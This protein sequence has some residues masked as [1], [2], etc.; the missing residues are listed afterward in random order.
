MHRIPTATRNW[1]ERKCHLRIIRNI[2]GSIVSGLVRKRRARE[3]S[4]PKCWF[5]M[6]ITPIAICNWPENRCHL[7]IIRNIRGSS[8]SGLIRE[9]RVQECPYNCVVLLPSSELMLDKS[10]LV[11]SAISLKSSASTKRPQLSSCTAP[12][13]SSQPILLMIRIISPVNV[14]AR[15]KRNIR[16]SI[17]SGLVRKRRVRET[18]HPKFWF[19][20]RKTPIATRNWPEY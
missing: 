6:H 16:G 2:R 9:R 10:M 7:R 14:P 15:S 4:Y 1:P 8:F 12:L 5:P 18:S 17:V 11:M 19:R 3:T 13:P 20:W